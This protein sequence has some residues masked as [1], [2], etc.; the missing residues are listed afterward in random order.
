MYGGMRGIPSLI[1]DTS[2]VD[3]NTGIKF[4]GLSIPECRKLLPK[5]KGG[6]E[7]LPESVFWLLITGD[8]PTQA[9]VKGISK[10]FAERGILAPY[11]VKML[12]NFPKNVH[13]MSQLAS[14]LTAMNTD[15]KFRKAYQK[16][17]KKTDYWEVSQNLCEGK[18]W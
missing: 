10:T 14:V 13:P 12:K 6:E 15:S 18:L 4:R 2:E 7:P 9:Q 5:A 1:C 8:V 17:V 11:V 16:G 3:Q